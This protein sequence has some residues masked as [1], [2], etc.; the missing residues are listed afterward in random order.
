MLFKTTAELLPFTDV[1]TSVK[2]MDVQN[3]IVY[4]EEKIIK[5]LLGKELY[6]ELSNNYKTETGEAPM[7]DEMQELLTY[8]RKVIGPFVCHSYHAK[9]SIQLSSAG[10]QRTEGEA[11]K[12]SYAY[13]DAAFKEQMLLEGEAACESLLE[14]LNNHAN[15]FEAY[16]NSIEYKESQ[17]LFIKSGVQ[18]NKHYTTKQPYKNYW[19]M[20]FKMYEVE[21]LTIKKAIGKPLYDYLKEKS[22]DATY[23][24]NAEEKTL[25]LFIEKSIAFFT[26]AA[27]LPHINVEINGNEISVISDSSGGIIDKAKRK[28]PDNQQL[29]LLMSRCN[30]SGNRWLNEALMYIQEN[31][32]AF[33]AWVAPAVTVAAKS[34]NDTLVGGFG[35]V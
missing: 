19:A 22:A 33:T 29:S 10:S 32:A 3:T 24:L 12:T 21:L 25:L 5:Q 14:Y 11:S 9:A 30:D 20:R 26:V 15:D 27:S 13:Q 35:L 31:V 23:S 6:D 8:C 18:F 16:A 2:I 17:L 7:S 34:N 1:L 28:Q 4:V